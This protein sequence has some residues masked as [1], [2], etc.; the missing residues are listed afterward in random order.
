[1]APA[2]PARAAPAPAATLLAAL[3]VT[4]TGP[5]DVTEADGLPQV[6]VLPAGY[7]GEA[8]G[9]TTGEETATGAADVVGTKGAQV[10]L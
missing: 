5:D 6:V 9:E 10:P 7:T 1:M 2:T 8:T 4:W 3:A